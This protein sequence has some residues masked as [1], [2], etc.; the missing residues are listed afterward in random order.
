M[1]KKIFTLFAVMAV[2][3]TM[4]AAVAQEAETP[5]PDT[6]EQMVEPTVDL[7]VQGTMTVEGKVV[8]ASP[9]EIVLET[10][11]GREVF[12]LESEDLY[13]EPIPEGANV[14]VSFVERA[15]RLYATELEVTGGSDYESEGALPQTASIQPLLAFLGLT[16]LALA[17]AMTLRRRL[18]S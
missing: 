13:A 4:G 12:L 7:D 6:Q 9:E 8:N 1:N 14:K 3:L 16:A 2:A 10:E 5:E 18:Q 17:G 15:D 11:D